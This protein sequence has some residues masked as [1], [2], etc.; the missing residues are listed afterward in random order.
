METIIGGSPKE[1]AQ[2]T[3]TK[4]IAFKDKV[5]S[6]FAVRSPPTKRQRT[7]KTMHKTEIIIFFLPSL[8]TWK[9]PSQKA[10][11]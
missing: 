8:K 9:T 3:A 2:I 4:T 7:T 5:I 10:G 6:V 1:I 11:W